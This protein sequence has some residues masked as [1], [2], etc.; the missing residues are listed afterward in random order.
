MNRKDKSPINYDLI[1]QDYEINDEDDDVLYNIKKA[2][3]ELRP[4][5]RKIFLVYTELGSF[6]GVARQFNVSAPTAKTYINNIK[7]KILN[8]L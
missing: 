5:E 8:S 3:A 2:L 7:D 1:K 4:M 6:A